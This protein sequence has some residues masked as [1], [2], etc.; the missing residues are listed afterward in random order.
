MGTLA[1][2][3]AKLRAKSREKETQIFNEAE[4]RKMIAAAKSR[5][6]GRSRPE[7][8]DQS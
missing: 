6:Y 5:R 3:A 1:S 2:T 4:V 7:S 8:A